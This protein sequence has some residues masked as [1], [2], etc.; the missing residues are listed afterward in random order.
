MVNELSQKKF[1]SFARYQLPAIVWS[2][3]IFTMSSIPGIKFPFQFFSFDKLLHFGVF[4]VLGM[5]SARAFLFQ[6]WNTTLKKYALLFA[7]LY[8]MLYGASDEI[9]QMFVPGRSPELYDFLA[10]TLGGILAAG[11]VIILPKKYL[12]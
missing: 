4:F 11:I 12:F 7:V 1:P 8:V 6:E 2:L 3:F 10:D 5:L 9:H